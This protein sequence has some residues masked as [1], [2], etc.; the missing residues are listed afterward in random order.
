M[1][2]LVVTKIAELLAPVPKPLL[3][4]L[5]ATAAVLLFTWLA[6]KYLRGFGYDMKALDRIPGPP[7]LPL[8]GNAWELAVDHTE[9][10]QVR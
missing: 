1:T 6:F 10:I 5:L 2:S 8:V 4:P 7:G 3:V 9:F